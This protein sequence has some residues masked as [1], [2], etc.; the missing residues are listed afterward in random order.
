[1]FEWLQQEILEIKTARFHKVDGPADPD[2]QRSV[3]QSRLALPS[4]YSKFVLS[5]GN[6]KLYRRSRDGYRIGVF[7]G[8]RESTLPDGT[9]FFHIGYNDGA[10]V[11]IKPKHP[12]S[13]LA[14]Y[15]FDEHL[16]EKVADDFE[17]WLM[18]SCARARNQ[19]GKEKWAD[20]LHGPPP[21]HASRGKNHRDQTT[22][23]VA[24][25]WD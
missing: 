18:A 4:T 2:L 23:R 22:N 5:F 25:A 1:M 20:I 13:K 19:Y 14:I 6:A 24:G 3:E 17:E 15:E 11:Y 12:S 16:E 9:R 8:P 10:S 7:A 21:F